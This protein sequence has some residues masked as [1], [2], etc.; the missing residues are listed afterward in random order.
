MGDQGDLSGGVIL[1]VVIV[2]WLIYLVPSWL[3]RRQYSATEKQVT[4]MQQALRVMSETSSP[5][6]QEVVEADLTAR[7]VAIV[8]RE[9]RKQERLA[10]KAERER[11]EAWTREMGRVERERS[12]REK[13]V[14][15]M[16]AD[17]EAERIRREKAAEAEQIR[18]SAEYRSAALRRGR[19][20]ATSISGVGLLTVVVAVIA[21]SVGATAWWLLLIG[22]AVSVLGVEMLRA[23]ARTARAYR[24]QGVFAAARP[25]SATGDGNRVTTADVEAR[26]A[27][28]GRTAA[29]GDRVKESAEVSNS[30]E[31]A[32]SSTMHA[33]WTP[34]RMPTPIYLTRQQ[35][36]EAAQAEAARAEEAAASASATDAPAAH[37]GT[38]AQASETPTGASSTVSAHEELRAAAD[39]AVSALRTA[40]ESDDVTPIEAADP[41]AEYAWL[42][43]VEAATR[44]AHDKPAGT[45]GSSSSQQLDDVLRR[46]RMG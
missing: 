9:A 42:E 39:A 26:D 17:V 34:Q 44:Q 41:D 16:K 10:L 30:V 8:A 12:E 11:A 24:R 5:E 25:R 22:G 31:A 15:R 23:A 40:A 7:K 43:Q 1:A 35:I 45:P 37:G 6:G 32:E 4:R 38:A 19:L 27:S 29:G 20:L 33:E 36:L 13:E 21:M 3:R 2:L 28:T 18:H 46:R 14:A